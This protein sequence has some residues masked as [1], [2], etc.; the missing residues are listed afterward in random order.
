MKEALTVNFDGMVTGGKKMTMLQTAYYFSVFS[1]GIAHESAYT[2]FMNRSQLGLLDD[3]KNLGTNGSI[4]ELNTKQRIW[5]NFRAYYT[6]LKEKTRTVFAHIDAIKHNN[7]NDCIGNPESSDSFVTLLKKYTAVA[8]EKTKTNYQRLQDLIALAPDPDTVPIPVTDPLST[9]IELVCSDALSSLFSTK[10]KRFISA[11]YGY[12]SSMEDMDILANSK[13]EADSKVYLETGKSP[14]YLALENFLKG[15]VDPILQE[16]GIVIPNGIPTTS[17]PFLTRSLFDAQVYPNFILNASSEIPK[18]VSKFDS[19]NILSIGFTR[20]GTPISTPINLEFLNAGNHVNPCGGVNTLNWSDIADF[21]NLYYVPNSYDKDLGTYKFQIIATIKRKGSTPAC[22]TPEEVLVEGITK[23]NIADFYPVNASA[24]CEKQER[25]SDA[26]NALV[27]TLQKENTLRNSNVDITADESFATGYLYEYFGIQQGDIVTWNNSG[28][29]A[30][31]SVNGE[32][33]VSLNFGTHF[34]GSK[35][36]SR[37]SVGNLLINSPYNLVKIKLR[38]FIGLRQ[39][40]ARISAGNMKRP[41]YFTCCSPC[42]ENDYNGDGLGD[43]C[44][45]NSPCGTIDSD[46]DGIFDDCDN[47]KNTP[48]PDQRDTDKDGIGDACDPY[49]P[50]PCGTIDSDGDGVFDNCDNC[51]DIPNPDQ[52]DTNNDGV[53]DSCDFP[54]GKIDSDGDGIYDDCDNCKDIPNPDQKDTNNNGIGDVCDIARINTCRVTPQIESDYED[55]LRTVLNE[56]IELNSFSQEKNSA[57]NVNMNHFINESALVEKFQVARNNY[58]EWAPETYNSPIELA[59]FS[60]NKSVAEGGGNP[61]FQIYFK[62]GSNQTDASISLQVN[63]NAVKK[64]NFID[65]VGSI[66][67]NVY[68]TDINNI[69][70]S[71]RV[72]IYNNVNYEETIGYTEGI[73]DF[74][75]F[76]IQYASRMARSTKPSISLKNRPYYEVKINDDGTVKNIDHNLSVA[77]SKAVISFYKQEEICPK[78]CVPAIPEPVICA[79]KWNAFKAELNTIIPGYVLPENL[80]INGTFFCEANYGYISDDY[81]YYLTKLKAFKG[82]ISASNALFLDIDKFGATRLHY[83][84]KDTH[85]VINDYFNFLVSI[86]I[87]NPTM[88]ALTWNQFADKYV[89]DYQKCAP[90]VMI[91]RFSLEV[92]NPTTKTPCELYAAT[93]K[94]SNKQQIEDA[95]YAAKKGEFIQKYTKQA[96]EGIIETLRKTAAD[97]EYQYTLYYYDQAGNL[98]QTVPPEGVHRL[99]PNSNAEID[100]IR[101]RD[102]EKIDLTDVNGIKVVPQNEMQ[103]QYRY[104]SLNQLVWQQTPDGGITQFAYDGLGRIIA[105]QNAKQQGLSQL[106]YTRYDKLGRITEAGQLTLKTTAV[107]NRW[108]Q[109]INANS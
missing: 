66:T 37:I 65:I 2:Q 34:F 90:A 99:M 105:S 101:K 18:I 51:K 11:D 46:G 38:G 94:A 80:T 13:A 77:A 23:I 15:M 43:D 83:G 102:T 62:N 68:Y 55:N 104:N 92:V 20:G 84:N 47:C 3:I 74:L 12:D 10:E 82:T 31:I 108:I 27:L 91:P 40:N 17:M 19:S 78:I 42:G 8:T 95:F 54:C 26:F 69:A 85:A 48:N 28:S 106:S 22:T 29:D 14:G 60:V 9:G 73:C 87:P 107:I 35:V 30:N 53:G 44:D 21:K 1:N 32:K 49:S 59:T 61:Y 64:I 50:N 81:A 71:A 58:L 56:A 70:R 93:I 33:R 109:L 89:A 86:N 72:N 100:T 6:G 39:I 98:I 88:E 25:F 7:Y 67:A 63:A 75:N 16:Q 52:K 5:S 79:E 57:S 4:I 103:T 36:I 24:S 76:K 41:L 96:L 45:A 97:K